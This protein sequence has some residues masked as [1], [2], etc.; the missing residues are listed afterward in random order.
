MKTFPGCFG[1]SVFD[2]L[3]LDRYGEA[4]GLALD[5]INA[6]TDA[7]REAMTKSRG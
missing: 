4:Y 6:E 5:F 1:P 2:D 3:S 7:M